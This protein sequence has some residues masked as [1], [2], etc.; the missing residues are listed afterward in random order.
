M[1]E[2]TIQLWLLILVPVLTLAAGGVAGFFIALWYF[3]RQQQKNPPINEGMIRAMFRQ[4]GRTPS[5][6]QVR[7]I[8]N[9]MNA[10]SKPKAK[11]KK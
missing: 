1:P 2:F 5:E 11:A 3:K 7:A 4:M 8:M 9:S 10:Q 6:S